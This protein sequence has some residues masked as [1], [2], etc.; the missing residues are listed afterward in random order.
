MPDKRK[1]REGDFA[2]ARING[3]ATGEREKQDREGTLT[4]SLTRSVSQA[5]TQSLHVAFACD[6]QRKTDDRRRRKQRGCSESSLS[7]SFSLFSR[8]TA[9][10]ASICVLRSRTRRRHP[11]A[12]RPLLFLSSR[13][14]L[15]PLP[16]TQTDRHTH[17]ETQANAHL[18]AVVA[19]VKSPG[20]RGR[21]DGRKCSLS[22][23]PLRSLCLTLRPPVAFTLDKQSTYAL[24]LSHANTH[25]LSLESTDRQK[26]KERERAKQRL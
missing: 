11:S 19:R 14:S 4:H 3:R 25:T 2:V 7:H 22:L 26:E 20:E 5:L 6:Q 10:A 18:P 13:H 12:R 8:A 17:S 21:K 16:F 15:P 9:A 24:S 1:A 23:A